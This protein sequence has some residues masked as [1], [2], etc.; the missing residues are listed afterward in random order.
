[1]ELFLVWVSDFLEFL[2]VSWQPQGDDKTLVC[3]CAKSKKESSTYNTQKQQC[4]VL[5]LFSVLF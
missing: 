5:L 4:D 1:M 3:H 2:L